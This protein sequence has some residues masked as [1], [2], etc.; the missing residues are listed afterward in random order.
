MNSSMTSFLKKKIKIAVDF[1]ELMYKLLLLSLKIGYLEGREDPRQPVEAYRAY[2][3]FRITEY[4]ELLLRKVVRK[5]DEAI[6]WKANIADA[7]VDA[8]PDMS[9]SISA[10]IDWEN[11]FYKP[12][13]NN[14]KSVSLN[15]ELV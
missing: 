11:Y 9:N 6:E 8:V 1:Q 12:L 2:S 10:L 5:E 13:E 4:R 15:R 7:D 14:S 3:Y